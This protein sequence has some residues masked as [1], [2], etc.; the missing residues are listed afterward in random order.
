LKN[1]SERLVFYDGNKHFRLVDPYQAYDE[2]DISGDFNDTDVITKLN[3][4]I[5]ID[6][7][8]VYVTNGLDENK[9]HQLKNKTLYSIYTLSTFKIIQN[10]L[11]GIIDQLDI[12]KVAS[13]E[14]IVLKDKV[15]FI[16]WGPCELVIRNY[17]N[18]HPKD[19]FLPT[20]N[21]YDDKISFENKNDIFN[22]H[23]PHIL[24]Y[25]LLN[26]QDLVMIFMKHS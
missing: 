5:F 6:N 9:L 14:K 2:I 25:K 19:T 24:S 4:K 10:M 23:I 18:F 21:G 8:N 7:D 12:K 20:I 13:P 22:Y 15:E 3:R 16:N 17:F 11:N 26:N 1:N